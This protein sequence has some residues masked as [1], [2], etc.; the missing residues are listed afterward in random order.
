MYFGNELSIISDHGALILRW[1]LT[2]HDFLLMISA[3]VFRE[4]LPL[5][6]LDRFYRQY[7]SNRGDRRA[8]CRWK[9]GQDRS[10]L[11]CADGER[12]VVL[13]RRQQP[14]MISTLSSF[15]SWTPEFLI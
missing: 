7:R 11:P 13:L 5:E 3:S 4:R 15:C 14:K 12:V 8:A 6:L 1:I 2:E 9:S 10:A